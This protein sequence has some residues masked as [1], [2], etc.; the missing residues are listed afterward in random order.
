[1][2]KVMKKDVTPPV[3]F[4]AGQPLAL[5]RVSAGGDDWDLVHVSVA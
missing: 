3:T 4:R 2:K 1:M 5:H